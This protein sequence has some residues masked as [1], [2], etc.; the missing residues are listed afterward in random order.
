MGLGWELEKKLEM[1]RKQ[2]DLAEMGRKRSG[3]NDLSDEN[4]N[5]KKPLELENDDEVKVKENK[6]KL[7]STTTTATAAIPV[8]EA[9][10][11]PRNIEVILNMHYHILCDLKTFISWGFIFS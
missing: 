1:L 4:L 6:P 8:E 2:N 10:Q 5:K 3:T 11:E 7:K 9:I